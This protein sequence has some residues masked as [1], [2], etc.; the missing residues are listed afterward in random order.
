MGI[1]TD[2]VEDPE[3]TVVTGF[4]KEVREM[5]EGLD[6]PLQKIAM[7]KLEGYT[8]QEISANLRISLRS[9]ER[10]LQLIRQKWESLSPE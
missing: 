2:Q 4:T 1:G 6:E 7:K 5:L 3:P 8:N 10:K 9:V